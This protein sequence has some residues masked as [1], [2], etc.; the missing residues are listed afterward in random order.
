MVFHLEWVFISEHIIFYTL[1][2]HSVHSYLK[3]SHLNAK[4][5]E[6]CLFP[7]NPKDDI[8]SH[9]AH[10]AIKF[11]EPIIRADSHL[12]TLFTQTT[13]LL[14]TIKL[15]FLV[16][17][18][19]LIAY[20]VMDHYCLNSFSNLRSNASLQTS[21]LQMTGKYHEKYSYIKSYINLSIGGNRITS[22]YRQIL[23]PN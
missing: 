7:I 16:P 15:I 17:K 14:A 18:C 23:R 20:F 5:G 10:Y 22:N 19:N 11:V 6:H 1:E 13:I 9:V 12:F 4:K 21:R 3:Q 2:N 8:S